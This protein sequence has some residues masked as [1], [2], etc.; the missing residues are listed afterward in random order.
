MNVN[1][2][3]GLLLAA[4]FASTTFAAGQG[5]GQV[6]FYGEIIDAPCSVSP[7]SEDQRI[8]MGQVSN[9]EL[10]KGKTSVTPR[11]FNIQ[12]ENCSMDTLKSVQVTFAGDPDAKD[13][14]LL[15]LVG[16]AGG[17]GVKLVDVN[18]ANKAIKL[19]TATDAIAMVDGDKTLKFAAHLKGN[20]V[21][22]D[23]TAGDFTATTTFT[24]AY[25]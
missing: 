12:L 5:S 8:P 13:A 19:G 3:M 1:K 7:D 2:L 10:D 21:A 11:A 20:D 17:A 14:D 23:V 16:T 25:Q 4:G 6:E 18:N 9:K 24:L 22:A 15:K